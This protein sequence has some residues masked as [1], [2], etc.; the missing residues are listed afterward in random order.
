MKC[1]ESLVTKEIRCGE[2]HKRLL[3]VKA[4]IYRAGVSP[5]KTPG[6]LRFRWGKWWEATEAKGCCPLTRLGHGAVGCGSTTNLHQD[7][8]LHPSGKTARRA[9]LVSLW[10]KEDQPFNS[11]RSSLSLDQL[12]S[13]LNKSGIVMVPKG[14]PYTAGP[15]KFRAADLVLVS[16]QRDIWKVQISHSRWDYTV[17]KY[18]MWHSSGTLQHCRGQATCVQRVGGRK[19]WLFFLL[20]VVVHICPT[21]T[22]PE[23]EVGRDRGQEWDKLSAGQHSRVQSCCWHWCASP[24]H[25]APLRSGSAFQPDNSVIL[26]SSYGFHHVRKSASPL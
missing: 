18:R 16:N 21:N 14:L 24:V 12:R 6:A 11:P 8:T 5:Y 10:F 20:Q 2:P 17:L 19:S 22:T 26:L 7:P 1:L 9:S 3:E 23:R 15:Y 13:G 4:Q 25:K